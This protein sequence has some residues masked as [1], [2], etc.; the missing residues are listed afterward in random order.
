MN[1]VLL[2][3]MPLARRH[4][5]SMN[6][7]LLKPLVVQ[8]GIECDVLYPNHLFGNIAGGESYDLAYEGVMKSNQNLALLEWV[9][10]EALFGDWARSK[11]ASVDSLLHESESSALRDVLQKLRCAVVPF[12]DRCISVIPW[13]DYDVVG[14]SVYHP[15][16]NSSLALASEI[17]RRFPEMK[18]AMGGLSFLGRT[19]TA[20]MKLFPFIDWVFNGEADLSFPK[21][22]ELMREGKDP[23]GVPGVSFR[24]GGDIVEQGFGE[25]ID[26]EDLP[27]FDYRDFFSS[28]EDWAPDIIENDGVILLYMFSRGCWWAERSKCVFCGIPER[29]VKFRCKPPSRIVNELRALKRAFEFKKVNIYDNVI[30]DFFYDTVLPVLA[31]E[32]DVDTIQIEVRSNDMTRDRLRSVKSGRILYPLAGIDTLDSDCHR[33]LRKGTDLLKVLTFLKWSREYDISAIWAFLYGIPGET[34]ES[35]LRIAELVPSLY[36][37]PPPHTHSPLQLLRFSPMFEEHRELG[38][39]DPMPIK[40]YRAIYPFGEGDLGE[41]AAVFESRWKDNNPAYSA[42]RDCIAAIENWMMS[43]DDGAKPI[44]VHKK[45]S[46]GRLAVFDTRPSCGEFETVLEGQTALSYLACET[47]ASFSRIASTVEEAMG[48]GYSGRDS[49]MDA[50]DE[51]LEYRLVVR[52]KDRYLSLGNDLDV[53]KKYCKDIQVQLLAAG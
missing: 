23:R 36:H 37:L 51:L 29:H 14:F 11:G 18:I 7:G 12:I 47:Q 34:P 49:T 30:P 41:I 16:L 50:I 20:L 6:L 8:A 4:M 43:W 21:A 46:E 42:I 52:D 48:D 33:L 25:P 39:P 35:Y 32:L 40:A 38:L 17:K 19:G 10:S 5:P 22:L 27:D 45:L 31:D 28:L 44:L 13:E 1:K 9:F 53:M 3:Y 24:S 2:L 15:Q 26:V